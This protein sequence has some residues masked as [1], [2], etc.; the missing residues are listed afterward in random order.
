MA[1]NSVMAR[2]MDINHPGSLMQDQL[3]RHCPSAGPEGYSERGK[4]EHQPAPL[5]SSTDLI[6][7][8]LTAQP[9]DIAP[10]ERDEVAGIVM[11]RIETYP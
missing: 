7:N 4:R 10:P 11:L 5:P 6:G 8:P 2:G 1:R 9:I 3:R